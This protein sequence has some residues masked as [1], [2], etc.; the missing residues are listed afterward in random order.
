MIEELCDKL[1]TVH[2]TILTNVGSAK[3]S[4]SIITYHYSHISRIITAAID[5]HTELMNQ[6]KDLYKTAINGLKRNLTKKKSF[7][8]HPMP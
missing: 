4:E 7:Y 6:I 2:K 1:E 8:L 3:E 5:R